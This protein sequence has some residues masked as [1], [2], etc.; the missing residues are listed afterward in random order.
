LLLENGAR[1]SGSNALYRALDFNS[2][3][4]LGLLLQH[5]ADPNER[6]QPLTY[7]GSPLLWAIKRR[8]SRA[9]VEALLKAGADPSAKTGDGISAYSFVLQL[10]LGEVAA[11]LAEHGAAEP[12]SQ[13]EEFIAACARGDETEARRIRSTRADLPAALP[14]AQLRTLPDLAAERRR[15]SGSWSNW[16]GRLLFAAATG[17][18]PRLISRCFAVTPA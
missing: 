8:R 16:A 12:V 11:L 13:E 6:N 14:P 15:P 7:W 10:G 18:R 17:T 5:G 2:I 9:H 4:V 3:A 1:I